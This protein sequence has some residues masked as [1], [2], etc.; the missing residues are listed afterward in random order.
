[1][2]KKKIQL[3]YVPVGRT[4]LAE[5]Y[6]E[7]MKLRDEIKTAKETMTIKKSDYFDLLYQFLAAHVMITNMS[8]IQD[9]ELLD[10][11][12]ED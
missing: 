7:L 9:I 3:T 10:A 8:V 2:S 1:M 4:E 12:W 5:R 11:D 6:Q